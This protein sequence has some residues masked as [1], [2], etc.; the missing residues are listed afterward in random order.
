MNSYLVHAAYNTFAGII[1]GNDMT[2]RKFKGLY[3]NTKLNVALLP[4]S[5]ASCRIEPTVSGN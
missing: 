4:A 2:E 5:I 3:E 1:Y